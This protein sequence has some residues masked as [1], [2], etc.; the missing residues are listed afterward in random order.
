MAKGIF[1]VRISSKIQHSKPTIYPIRQCPPAA[2]SIH[3]RL[4]AYLA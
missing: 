4:G 1:A 3:Q 2:A